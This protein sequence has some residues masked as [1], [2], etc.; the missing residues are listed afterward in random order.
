MFDVLF[1]CSALIDSLLV[2]F[3][4][5]FCVLLK[6]SFVLGWFFVVVCLVL[7]LF[8]LGGGGEWAKAKSLVHIHDLI[9]EV[10]Q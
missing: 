1:I 7:L 2:C 6:F 8:F 4:F 3:G 5:G 10:L 9:Y